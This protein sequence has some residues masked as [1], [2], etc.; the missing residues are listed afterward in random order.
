MTQKILLSIGHNGKFK[1]ASFGKFNEY[2]EAS[3]WVKTLY[4]LLG[5]DIAILGLE[6]KLKHKVNFANDSQ[7][8]IA[9][10][11]H[12]NS[13]KN[14]N[15]INVGRGSETLYCP[16][17]VKGKVLATAV[18]RELGKIFKPS[19]GAKEGW[20]QMRNYPLYRCIA[21]DSPDNIKYQG[22]WSAIEAVAISE[23]N[24]RT[25][26]YSSVEVK[27]PKPDYF[28]A[29]TKMT[30][31]IIEP[32]FIHRKEIIQEHRADACFRLSGVLKNYLRS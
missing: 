28:L 31:I 22:T 18:Q 2:D 6:G 3:V 5:K 32:D 16:K 17:S 11:I 26:K 7:A 21:G 14:I 27:K 1:G 12:F 8:T 24:R 4:E 20:Y 19:R 10:E 23:C 30:A 9:V 13:A 29:K 25:L 15:G